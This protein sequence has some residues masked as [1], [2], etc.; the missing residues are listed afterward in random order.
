[1]D[2]RVVNNTASER[3]TVSPTFRV[4]GTAPTLLAL[5]SLFRHSGLRF[6]GSWREIQMNA[7]ITLT[8]AALLGSIAGALVL[9]SAAPAASAPRTACAD[10]YHSDKQGNCQPNSPQPNLQPCPPGYLSAPSPNWSGY[11]CEPIPKGY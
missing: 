10:G 7:K 4:T 5:I 8:A 2:C 9:G 11:S 3:A 6:S 1:M